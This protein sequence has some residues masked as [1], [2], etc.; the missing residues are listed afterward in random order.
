MV[1]VPS[2]TAARVQ[3]RPAHAP[4]EGGTCSKS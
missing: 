4:A 1:E 3:P 2:S